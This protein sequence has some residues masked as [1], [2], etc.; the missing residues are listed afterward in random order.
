M[1]DAA[2]QMGPVAAM[3]AAAGRRA[4]DRAVGRDERSPGNRKGVHR[5]GAH[6]VELSGI[7]LMNAF[8]MPRHFVQSLVPGNLL[9]VWIDA[10]ALFRVGPAQGNLQPMRIVMGHDPRDPL[11]A[12]AA[13]AD[14]AVG[15]AL[16]LGDYSID[17]MS[18]DRARSI[19]KAAR[20]RHP[21]IVAGAGSRLRA[22]TC[23][24]I[25]IDYV[26]DEV[27]LF[28]LPLSMD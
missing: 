15:V 9:P 13:L 14:H 19:T 10:D 25:R 12:E 2:D 8:E 27:P 26:H 22:G 28:M 23:V 21:N 20:R 1:H 4:V 17:A 11:A 3:Q 24:F 5:G 7:I 18:E 6:G 16:D